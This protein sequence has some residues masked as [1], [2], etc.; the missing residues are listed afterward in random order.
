[1]RA[2]LL[3]NTTYGTWLPGDRRGSVTSVR[4]LRPGDEPSPFRFEHD[5]PGEPY[6]D[7]P[8]EL[9]YGDLYRGTLPASRMVSPGIEYYFEGVSAEGDRTAIFA[10][11]GQPVRVII[12]GDDTAEPV[13]AAAPV[14]PKCKSICS[15]IVLAPFKS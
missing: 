13:V 11:A 15:L 10:S 5:L 6:E 14:K 9:Q 7:F 4:D 3:S 12:I 1:M 2:W 8:L